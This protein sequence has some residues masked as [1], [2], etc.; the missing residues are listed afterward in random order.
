MGK[1]K[2][3]LYTGPISR[4]NAERIAGEIIDNALAR[5]VA[6]HEKL[7]ATVKPREPYY[8]YNPHYEESV[9]KACT[10]VRSYLF[11]R[12]DADPKCQPAPYADNLTEL[13]LELTEKI[14]NAI[15]NARMTVGF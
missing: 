15:C 11:A 2:A 10:I 3:T 14:A 4:K 13:D 1:K 12:H 9:R 5:D 6:E 7:V 8:K